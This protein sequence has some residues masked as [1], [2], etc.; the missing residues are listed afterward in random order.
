MWLHVFFLFPESGGKVLEEVTAMFEDPHGI[1]YIGTP[2]WKT[3][4]STKI[5]ARLEANQDLEKKMSE[6]ELPQT[7][8]VAP[9][10]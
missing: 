4:T 2:A 10:A 7:H 5:T 6:E 3:K 9:K 1:P 8:E